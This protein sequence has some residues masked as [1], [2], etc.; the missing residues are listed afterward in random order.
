MSLVDV[1][2]LPF[3]LHLASIQRTA[4]P[5]RELLQTLF[6]P[7]SS[8]RFLSFTETSEEVSLIL[9]EGSLG[10][11]PTDVLAVTPGVW[12]AIQIYEGS[13]PRAPLSDRLINRC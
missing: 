13:R 7:K 1:A 3:N 2:I 4:L 5:T 9:D 10:L 11:F 8:S 12:A 6:F